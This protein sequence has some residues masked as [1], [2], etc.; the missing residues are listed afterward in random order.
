MLCVQQSKRVRSS[1]VNR[2]EGPSGE[3]EGRGCWDS[4]LRKKVEVNPC[5]ELRGIRAIFSNILGARRSRKTS[6]DWMR[7]NMVQSLGVWSQPALSLN[8]LSVHRNSFDF[9]VK[10]ENLVVTFPQG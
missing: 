10:P 3:M 2:F 6:K 5:V 9:L 4:A 7:Q 1:A 8:F